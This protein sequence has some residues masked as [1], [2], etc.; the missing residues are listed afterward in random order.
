MQRADSPSPSE[1]TETPRPTLEKWEQR[2][3]SLLLRG[4]FEYDHQH[5][6]FLGTGIAINLGDSTIYLGRK[7]ELLTKLAPHLIALAQGSASLAAD[8]TALAEVR[9]ENERLR[10]ALTKIVTC[11]DPEAPLQDARQSASMMLDRVFRWAVAAL[12]STRD[13][14]RDTKEG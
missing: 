14:A 13:T 4:E 11:S 5:P 12:A 3:L 8:R 9:D 2:V 10:E 1:R 7:G 6:M